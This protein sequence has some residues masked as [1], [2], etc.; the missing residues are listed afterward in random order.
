MEIM[1]RKCS[2]I[3]W[4]VIA[5]VAVLVLWKVV[6]FTSTLPDRNLHQSVFL[7]SGQ[8][9]FGHLHGV[10]SRYPYLT[11]VYYLNS[12]QQSSLDRFGQPGAAGQNFT[13]VKRGYN[14]IFAPTD[15][16]YL[17]RESILYWENVG[18]DSLIARGI[19]ADKDYRA[20]NAAAA[21][22]AAP[23]G[24]AMEKTTPAK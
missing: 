19:V 20:K 7:T 1:Q 5:L 4:A 24:A 15:K 10:H 11:D 9:V 3:T 22:A 6:R 16:M 18:S 8:F 13:V 21:E 2:R 14:E 12:Q 17:L 23:S